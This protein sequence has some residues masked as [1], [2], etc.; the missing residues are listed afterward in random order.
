M[1]KTQKSKKAID[2][3]DLRNLVNEGALEVFVHRDDI[4]I[5]DT[6]NEETVRIGSTKLKERPKSK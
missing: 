4:Y 1:T 2:L 5:R 3:V 6:E